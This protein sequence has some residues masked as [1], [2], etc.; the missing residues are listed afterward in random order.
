MARPLSL[1][2]VI[3]ERVHNLRRRSEEKDRSQETLPTGVVRKIVNILCSAGKLCGLQ[4]VSAE[5]AVFG[6]S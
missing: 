5:V 4:F 6:L 2:S 3:D 1:S